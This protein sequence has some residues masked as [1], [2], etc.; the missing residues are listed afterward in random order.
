M[1]VLAPTPT[2]APKAAARFMKGLATAMPLMPMSPTPCP[3]KMLSTMLYTD[4]AT[5]ATMAGRA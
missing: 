5:M 3:T 1:T 4:E 2:I